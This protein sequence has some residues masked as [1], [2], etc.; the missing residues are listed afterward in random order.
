MWQYIETV[1]TAPFAVLFALGEPFNLY[2]LT[3]ATL[4]ALLWYVLRRRR[5]IGGRA[6]AFARAAL[7]RRVW[8]HRSTILDFKLFFVSNFFNAAGIVG[9]FAISYAISAAVQSVLGH[10]VAAA[11]PA[12]TSVPI[13]IFL[14]VLYWIVFDL[15]YW[16]AHWLM[17]RIPVLWEFHKVHHSA[18][19]LT[20]LTQYRQHPVDT[21]L[22]LVVMGGANGLAIG[23]CAYVSGA[24][25][26][27]II[28][29]TNAVVFLFNV[30]GKHLRHSHVPISYGPV[31]S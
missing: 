20:P 15:G 28:L 18:E 19:V 3:G 16:F 12:A 22:D 10:V 2:S 14:A 6:R 4:T 27:F 23:V 17:H 7:S 9:V 21:A 29:Q 5:S 1:L 31:F 13:A 24:P 26:G 8:G 25:A 11:P 30:L